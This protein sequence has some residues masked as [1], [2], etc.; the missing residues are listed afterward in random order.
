MD[1]GCKQVTAKD[2]RRQAILQIARDIFLEE[3][4]AAASMSAIAARLGGS[5]G[6]LYNYF[7]SKEELFKAVIQD[8]CASKIALMF[9]DM[10]AESGDLPGGLR[11]LGV[12]YTTIV[13]GEEVI[14]FSRVLISEVGRF[15]ELGR[16][17]YEAGPLQGARRLSTFMEE[18]IKAGRL[19]SD[20][21]PL[22]AAEQ[23]CE[24]CLS[25][26]YRKRLWAVMGQPSAE[27]IHGNVDAAVNT[28]MAAFGAPALQPV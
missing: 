14:R 20:I 26:L 28:F 24:L 13:L 1:D 17:M 25:G 16:I 12:R 22:R 27:E 10:I 4:Y 11:K 2:V 18:Q 7:A 21:S 15:P 23:F 19:R 5:K 8:Q 6:T 3:G 9:G